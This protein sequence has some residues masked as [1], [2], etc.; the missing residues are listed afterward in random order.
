[1]NTNDIPFSTFQDVNKAS[2]GR[3]IAFFGAG[4]VAAK[5]RRRL[6]QNLTFIVDNNPAMWGLAELDVEVCDPARLAQADAPKP[7]LL[8]CTTSFI[9]VANQLVGM[10][11]EPMRDFMVSPI[12]NDLRIIHNIEACQAKLLFTSGSPPKDE[13]LWGGGVYEL[14]IV[15]GEHTYR[16]VISGNAHGVIRFGE[17]FIA[18]DDHQGVIEFDRSYNI[19]R[20]GELPL[21]SRGHGI[22]YSKQTDRFY[23]AASH[24]DR[25]LILDPNLKIEGYIPLSHKFDRTQSPVHH[26]NDVCVHGTSLYVSM[27]SLTGNWKQ[28]VFDG[29]VLEFDLI[30]REKLGP[31]ITDLWMPH[32]VGVIDGR[33]VV[34]DSLRGGLRINNANASGVFPGFSRGLGYDGQFFYVGQSRN[35]NYSKN[36]GLSKNI[37]L[38]TSIIVFD[39]ETKVSRSMALPSRLSE[40]HGIVVI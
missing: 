23:V 24:A 2:E 12:L 40:I 29:V 33:I 18:V 13:P 28:D 14:S 6:G 20:C 15:D 1:M 27:F 4:N 35:R 3:D 37:S 25:I 9:D 38:D 16:K 30:T 21:G 10:G 39:N 8:I 31:V 11:Y 19:Q 36:L 32:N 22:T 34:L 7:F 5:T 17:N 26:C